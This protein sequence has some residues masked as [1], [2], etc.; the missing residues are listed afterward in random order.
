[1]FLEV[2]FTRIEGLGLEEIMA[3]SVDGLVVMM[4]DHGLAESVDR[5]VVMMRDHG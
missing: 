4:I 5:L 1:M 2:N 3:E